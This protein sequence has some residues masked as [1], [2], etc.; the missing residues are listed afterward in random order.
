MNIKAYDFQDPREALILS[1]KRELGALQTE[2]EHLKTTLHLNSEAQNTTR[3][4]S[5]GINQRFLRV[6]ISHLLIS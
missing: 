6:Y 3:S 4:E 1:L 5:T 2:N